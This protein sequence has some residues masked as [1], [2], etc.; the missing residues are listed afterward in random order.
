MAKLGYHF[1]FNEIKSFHWYPLNLNI[2][3]LVIAKE[4]FD[5][6]DETIQ[7]NGRFS[8]KVSL[9]AKFMMKYFISLRRCFDE[10]GNFWRKYYMV[11]ELKTVEFN[12]K[13]RLAV[14]VLSDFVG[15]PAYCRMLKG[16]FWQI[17]SYVAPKE[18][19]KVEEIE[20]VSKGGKVHRFKVT[21]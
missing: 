10:A 1:K 9:I 7:E 13:D 8:A 20:C 6:D 2:L 17:I 16:Y 15:H 11:G 12:E 18:K 19:L 5:W 21:W 4:A 14:L 3:Y